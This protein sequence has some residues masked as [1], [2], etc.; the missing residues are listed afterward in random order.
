MS[1]MLPAII[2]PSRVSDAPGM[3]ATTIANMAISLSGALSFIVNA[4]SPS[5]HPEKP[6]C[7]GV[8]ISSIFT[9]VSLYPPGEIA[10][11][12]ADYRYFYA[13]VIPQMG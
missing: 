12:G 2:L 1:P 6:P 5:I 11:A 9:L 10:G 3:R 13:C 4:C 8:E 7:A